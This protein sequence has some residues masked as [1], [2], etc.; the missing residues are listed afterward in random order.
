[1]KYLALLRGINV[2]GNN[3]IKMINLKKAFDDLGFASVQ[4]YIQSGNV[5]FTSENADSRMLTEKIESQLT[6]TFNYN[7]KIILID[8]IQLQQIADESPNGFGVDPVNYKYDFVFVREPLTAADVFKQIK[9]RDGVDSAHCG[10][11]ALYF[12]RL[13]ALSSRSYL[14]KLISLPVYKELSI[15]NYNTTNKLVDLM[16]KA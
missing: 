12:T 11:L 3:I 14:T 2:G 5:I 4:T 13:T 9:V 1:M 15:R 8:Q 7:S 6:K 10:S 16:N